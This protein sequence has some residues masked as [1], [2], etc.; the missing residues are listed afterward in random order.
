[1][2]CECGC[3]KQIEKRKRGRPGRFFS[4]ACRSRYHSEARRRGD[5]AL[6]RRRRAHGAE[7]AELMAMSPEERRIALGKAAMRMGLLP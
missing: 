6:R 4:T 2:I 7:M 3:G 5:K 1:M